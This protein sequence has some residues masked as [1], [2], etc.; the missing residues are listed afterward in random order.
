MQQGGLTLGLAIQMMSHSSHA[1]ETSE[2]ILALQG[3]VRVTG[4]LDHKPQYF[5]LSWQVSVD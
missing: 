3:D 2:A 1:N 4:C 5:A